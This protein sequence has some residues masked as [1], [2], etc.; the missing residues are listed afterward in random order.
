M[1]PLVAP[2]ALADDPKLRERVA[3]ILRSEWV[4]AKGVS[5]MDHT[6]AIADRILQIIRGAGGR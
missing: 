1:S 3:E 6:G 4:A 5:W 2:P